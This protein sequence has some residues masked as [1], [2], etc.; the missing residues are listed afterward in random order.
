MLGFIIY[1]VESNGSWTKDA[2]EE[3]RYYII[4]EGANEN[5]H[6]IYLY[7]NLNS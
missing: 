1:K 3:D 6:D 2:T 7:N 5:G 4:P